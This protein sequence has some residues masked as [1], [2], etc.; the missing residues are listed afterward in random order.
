MPFDRTLRGKLS[1]VLAV[2]TCG[3]GRLGDA[4]SSPTP[5]IATE[6]AAA[7]SPEAALASRPPPSFVPAVDLALSRMSC[8]VLADG[9]LACWGHDL[10]GVP[11]LFPGSNQA[12]II[13]G[14]DDAVD[15]LDDFAPRVLHRDGRLT[16]LSSKIPPITGVRAVGGGLVGVLSDGRVQSLSQSLSQT[17]PIVGIEGA[18]R[19]CARPGLVCAVAGRGVRCAGTNLDG[20]EG[21]AIPKRERACSVCMGDKFHDGF[22]IP[23]F[24]DAVDITCGSEHICVLRERG[25]VECWG[26][27]YQGNLG[28]GG[29][30]RARRAAVASLD[31][32]TVIQ[33]DSGGWTTCAVRRGGSLVCWGS[34]TDA[35]L[36]R[37]HGL[38]AGPIPVEVPGPVSG[39]AVSRQSL[40]VITTDG[41]E[42]HCR[43]RLFRIAPEG[44]ERAELVDGWVRVYP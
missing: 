30:G 33:A 44:E 21:P 32:A 2:M 13:P 17:L 35:L 42:V 37:R 27:G 31:D 40:C 43:G 24:S 39:V 8:A 16:S 19:A 12:R 20:L 4:P 22:A 7:S 25:A 18:T 3:C 28:D 1:W 29:R 6:R 9:R 23:D 10:S 36:E 11:G 41:G 34:G 15:V 38:E 14:I 26:S 5:A